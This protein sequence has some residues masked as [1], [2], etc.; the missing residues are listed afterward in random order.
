MKAEEEENII[1][2]KTPLPLLL[3]SRR[4]NRQR[5]KMSRIIKA[6]QKK[7][8]QISKQANHKKLETE[9]ECM[10]GGKKRSCKTFVSISQNSLNV[11]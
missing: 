6:K 8:M 3:R 1:G 9:G 2:A 4:S 5:E 11:M 7:Q 10:S